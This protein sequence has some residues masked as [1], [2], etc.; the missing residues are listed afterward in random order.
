MP[1][2]LPSIGFIR[3][4]VAQGLS[5]NEAY[6]QYQQAAQAE[7]E[8]QGFH[9]T[10]SNR[11]TFLQQY[12]ATWA[13]RGQI[14]D[15]ITAP[16]DAPF[17]GLTPIRREATIPGAYLYTGAAFTRLP[18]TT[19]IERSIHMIRSREALTPQEVENRIR[20]QIESSTVEA[21]G[22]FA[23]YIIEGITFTGVEELIPEGTG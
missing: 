14:T 15:A 10:A 19:D 16:K 20:D 12:G 11:S 23:G 7:S 3:S 22:T 13:A 5:A 8:A 21:H 9:I 6:R 17:G 4:G 18:G 2:K 1:P